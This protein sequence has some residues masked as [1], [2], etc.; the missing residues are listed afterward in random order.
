MVAERLLLAQLS[1]SSRAG[2]LLRPHL[3]RLQRGRAVD[4]LR[5]ILRALHFA[6]LPFVS[7]C[8]C[9]PEPLLVFS[10]RRG[11]NLLC[12]QFVYIF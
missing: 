2:A 6:V 1:P 11:T 8:A 12:V 4:V 5:S 9:L 10:K 7:G 3:L